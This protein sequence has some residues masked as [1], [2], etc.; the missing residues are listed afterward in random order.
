[1]NL[2]GECPNP[3]CQ[4][5]RTISIITVIVFIFC[6]FLYIPIENKNSNASLFILTVMICLGAFFIGTLVEAS[7]QHRIY[8]SRNPLI[9]ERDD[10][11]ENPFLPA[12][13][14]GHSRRL[15]RTSAVRH[16]RKK[17]SG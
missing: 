4:R 5:W 17:R 11:N 3:G 12:R 2:T 14:R 6:L 10:E 13:R 15:R 7:N 8:L 16:H 9:K 1:M